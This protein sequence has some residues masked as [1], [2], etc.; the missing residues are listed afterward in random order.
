MWLKWRN[1][2]ATF[3]FMNV[4]CKCVANTPKTQM[5]ILFKFKLLLSL[6]YFR[7]YPHRWWMETEKLT[8]LWV[9]VTF[10]IYRWFINFDVYNV[11][12]SH[13]L[14]LFSLYY[15]YTISTSINF[16][17]SVEVKW[18]MLAILGYMIPFIVIWLTRFC[19]F[20]L[21]LLIVFLYFV[22]HNGIITKVGSIQD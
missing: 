6:N 10:L 15:V 7:I 1:K 21:L 18:I 9:Y 20:W 4:F 19:S 12:T 13:N 16:K 14:N 3:E 2:V 11:W 8:D 17:L 5:L 22:S